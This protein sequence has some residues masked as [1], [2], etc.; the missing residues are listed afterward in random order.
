MRRNMYFDRFDI[1]TA[2]YAFYTDYH[3]GQ[4][5]KKYER[6]SRISNPN[7]K[8]QLRVSPL[9]RGFESLSDNGKEIYKQL[10]ETDNN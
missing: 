2:H 3:E 1:V 9:W 7:G 4:W 8:I 5:S 10:V 6:L